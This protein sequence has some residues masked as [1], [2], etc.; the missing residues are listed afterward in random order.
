MRAASRTSL[1]MRRAEPIDRAVDSS[2]RGGL[3]D[4]SAVINVPFVHQGADSADEGRVEVV[5]RVGG[6]SRHGRRRFERGAA[7]AG[8]LDLANARELRDAVDG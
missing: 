1:Y 8:V 3:A 6:H 7:G 5:A 4:R 2:R